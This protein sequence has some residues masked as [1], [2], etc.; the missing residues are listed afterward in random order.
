M[1]FNL[2]SFAIWLVFF[3]KMGRKSTMGQWAVLLIAAE[4]HVVRH[5]GHLF[6]IALWFKDVQENFISTSKFMLIDSQRSLHPFMPQNPSF[7]SSLNHA[8]E[9]TALEIPPDGNGAL[10]ATTNAG[11]SS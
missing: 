9:A 10:L 4:V 6:C 8:W 1:N 5:P 7:C 2:F 11:R 3:S